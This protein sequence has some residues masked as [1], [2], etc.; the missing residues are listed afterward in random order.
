MFSSKTSFFQLLW[1]IFR[2]MTKAY[3][4]LE[5]AHLYPESSDIAYARANEDGFVKGVRMKDGRKGCLTFIYYNELK[6]KNTK[7]CCC[8][9]QQAGQKI[10]VTSSLL[11]FQE[12]RQANLDS[13][14]L[15]LSH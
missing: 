12:T 11:A 2:R 5:V 10:G 7:C 13:P 14:A 15:P 4:S 8:W 9:R 6:L 1:L 3:A